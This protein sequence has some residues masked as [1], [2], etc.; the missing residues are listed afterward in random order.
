[1]SP[2]LPH[3]GGRQHLVDVIAS[4]IVGHEKWCRMSSPPTAQQRQR[5]H[6]GHSPNRRVVGQALHHARASFLETSGG[7]RTLARRSRQHERC[8]NAAL[9]RGGDAFSLNKKCMPPKLR[10][11][12]PCHACLVRQPA[13]AHQRPPASRTRGC[14]AAMQ[15]VVAQVRL[16]VARTR[17]ARIYS[18]RTVAPPGFDTTP[19]PIR[20]CRGS[21]DRWEAPKSRP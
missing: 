3:T 10:H 12:P 16:R 13:V 18:P 2:V 11:P 8:A 9:K 5:H 21:T 14:I 19:R 20:E 7:P 1:M 15:S 17:C 6:P 4:R